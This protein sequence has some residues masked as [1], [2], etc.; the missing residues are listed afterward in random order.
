M[1]NTNWME[2]ETI[3]SGHAWRRWA[4][5]KFDDVVLGFL[6]VIPFIILL[7]L[8]I[9]GIIFFV[10]NVE[11]KNISWMENLSNCF[12]SFLSGPS[13]ARCIL[14]C[15]FLFMACII[16]IGLLSFSYLWLHSLVVAACM[17]YFGNTPGKQL[18]GIKIL[19][20]TGR[21]ITFKEAFKREMI[22]SRKTLYLL[23]PIIGV[24][25]YLIYQCRAYDNLILN[26][27]TTW[28]KQMHLTVSY[29]MQS[30]W[31]TLA[32]VIILVGLTYLLLIDRTICIQ[33]IRCITK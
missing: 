9:G 15:F 4:A 24:I 2:P 28:D 16:L 20:E 23:I 3:T 30:V 6:S 32:A 25:I 18:F 14:S 26:K 12:V 1:K 22:I 31:I 33:L 21:S 19:H 17:T 10:L 13:L 7:I 11:W 5:R 29:R 27:I 8:L